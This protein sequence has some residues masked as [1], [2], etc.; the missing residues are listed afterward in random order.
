LQARAATSLEDTVETREV[1]AEVVDR[2]A[3]P[4]VV[5]RTGHL[6]E[7]AVFGAMPSQETLVIDTLASAYV[8]STDKTGNW[9]TR[10]AP[11]LA[12]G[13]RQSSFSSNGRRVAC[14][15][16]GEA[17]VQD[18]ISGEI[19]RTFSSPSLVGELRYA[20][21]DVGKYLAISTNDQM[22]LVEVDSGSDWKMRL[23]SDYGWPAFTMAVTADGHFVAAVPSG[24]PINTDTPSFL[25]D[26]RNGSSQLIR[27]QAS[28]S[29]IA[30][31]TKGDLLVVGSDNGRIDILEVASRSV[32]LQVQGPPGLRTTSFS[33]DG[34]FLAAGAPSA[35]SV[36]AVRTGAELAKVST[37]GPIYHVSFDRAGWRL[38]TSATRADGYAGEVVVWNLLAGRQFASEYAISS[39]AWT[40][41]FDGKNRLLL[42]GHDGISAT[43]LKTG[44][45]TRLEVPH[46]LDVNSIQPSSGDRLALIHGRNVFEGTYQFRALSSGEEVVPAIEN[47]FSATLGDETIAYLS[48]LENAKDSTLHLR[49]FTDADVP[50]VSNAIPRSA[51]QISIDRAGLYI[52]VSFGAMLNTKASLAI[53]SGR[54]LKRLNAIDGEATNLIAR[55]I[56]DGSAVLVADGNRLDIRRLPNLK[57]IESLPFSGVIQALSV[58][59]QGVF[60]VIDASDTISVF[61]RDQQLLAR[62][63][64]TYQRSQREALA[65]SEDGETLA[66]LLSVS[67][68]GALKL[69]SLKPGRLDD[70]L[71]ARLLANPRSEVWRSLM[72]NDTPPPPCPPHGRIDISPHP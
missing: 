31:S 52:A 7:I 19:V 1:A 4:S 12:P 60:A 71:C 13:C 18:T 15:R 20:L 59:P 5:F 9:S 38:V 61:G 6:D 16:S 57:I 55:V 67:R 47:A 34:R 45:T 36:Y 21:D 66:V 44:Q 65:F 72:P 64:G 49:R 35:A 24:S 22:I 39:E 30:F 11:L 46:G 51:D 40:V 17:I 50:E 10:R 63:H 58:S 54:D 23:S 68:G 37:D 25:F 70:E 27:E 28:I 3:V 2:L 56:P 42:S 62:S 41:G 29:T 26:I 53:Y 14:T 48:S 33:D 43:D 32:A 8:L 69:M